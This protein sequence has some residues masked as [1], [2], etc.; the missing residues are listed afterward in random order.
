MDRRG[1]LLH[2]HNGTNLT[3][4]TLSLWLRFPQ[5]TLYGFRMRSNSLSLAQEEE[6]AAFWS[7]RAFPIAVPSWLCSAGTPDTS[8]T[9]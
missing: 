6:L 7:G 9:A 4:L 1:L 3:P 5:D 2:Y 8:A